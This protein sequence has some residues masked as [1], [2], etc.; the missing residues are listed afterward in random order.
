MSR[1]VS[2]IVVAAGRGARLGA[3]E[4]KA[5]WRLGGKPMYVHAVEALVRAGVGEVVVVVPADRVDD[6]AGKSVVG[7]RTRAESVRAGLAVCSSERV[8]VHDAARP[9]ASDGLIRRVLGALCPPWSAVA[10]ALEV[11][12]T[13]KRVEGERVTETVPRADLWAVQT[14]QV[15]LRDVLEAAH[16]GHDA[17]ATDDLVLVERLG[18]PVRLVAGERRNFKITFPEDLE[19]A[20]RLLEASP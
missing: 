18:E 3:G 17:D 12:D 16:A 2:G 5:F 14:P 19:M 7:G 4:P 20:E 10:P 1:G 8:A 15:F 13:L 6:V 11:A 9:L